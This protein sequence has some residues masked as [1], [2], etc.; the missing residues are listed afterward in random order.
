M[1]EDAS[2]MLRAFTARLPRSVSDAGEEWFED[3]YELGR[4]AVSTGQGVVDLVQE[5]ASA[6]VQA[7]ERRGARPEDASLVAVAGRFLAECLAPVEMAYRGYHGAVLELRRAN[8]EL[9][10][11]AEALEDA[12]RSLARLARDRQAWLAAA[13]RRLAA[14]VDLQSVVDVVRACGREGL[15]AACDVVLLPAPVAAEA[16]P[17]VDAGP[18]ALRARL[19]ARGRALGTATW[20][21]SSE[22]PVFTAEDAE[23][24]ADLAD[25]AALALDNA[26]LLKE[27]V[28]AVHAR[29]VFLA[30]ASHELRTPLTPAML[31]IGSLMRKLDGAAPEVRARAADAW[32][33]LER[34]QVLVED[35]LDVSAL[36]GATFQLRAERLDLVEIVRHLV[37]SST[38]VT[39]RAPDG[40]AF[41]SGDPVRLGQ[42][43]GNLLQNA[44]KYG[45][46]NSP[47]VVD[48]TRAGDEARVAVVDHGI[49]VPPE[50]R[51][52]VF[53]PFF[54]A[55]NATVE[56]YG[57]MG[58]GLHVS[59]EIVLRHGGRVWVEDAEGGGAR[60]VVALP[61][62]KEGA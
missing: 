54:R 23:R 4:A 29:D 18:R 31:K 10:A 53:E 62:A 51:E 50:D 17:V 41:V 37:G 59:K 33:S 6:V 8:A 20:T 45:P 46:P 57:G 27:A 11:R 25:R 30:I 26:R 61:L 15:D 32:K 34:L 7:L 13:S 47:V 48:V 16:G 40:P 35:L 38:Q 14:A 60:F 28:D 3:A 44:I 36:Q 9:R 21:R 52:R 43:V 39:V 22:A 55:R 49:G 1:I 58:L 56:H 2:R 19:V 5:H 24:A 42:V 12:H